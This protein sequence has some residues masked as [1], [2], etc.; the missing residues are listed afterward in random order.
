M[1]RKETLVLSVN[2]E[3]IPCLSKEMRQV[4]HCL[5]KDKFTK[6]Y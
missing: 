3:I 4:I 5:M 2:I 6:K 1:C